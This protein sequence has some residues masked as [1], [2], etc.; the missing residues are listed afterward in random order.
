MSKIFISVLILAAIS[1]TLCKEPWQCDISGK[2]ACSQSQTC[3][4]SKVSQTGWSCFPTQSGVCCSDGV[5]VCPTATICNLREKRC[6]RSTLAFLEVAKPDAAIEVAQEA[7]LN[8]VPAELV[9]GFLKG[10]GFFSNLPHENECKPED[11]QIAQDISEIINLLKNISIKTDFRKTIEQILT[12]ATDAY[13]R[14][15]KVSEVCA[16]FALELQH[17]VEG[18]KGYVSAKG[19]YSKLALHTAMNIGQIT[20]KVKTAVSDYSAAKFEEAGLAF[21]D[22]T[23]FLIFWGFNPDVKV[24]LEEIEQYE[25]INPEDFLTFAA[26]VNQG[27]RFFYMLPNYDQCVSY[28]P[29]VTQIAEE[30]F[31]IVK[32]LNIKNAMDVVRKV[33]VKGLEIIDIISKQSDACNIYSKAIKNVAD[34][35]IKKI[36]EKSYPTKLVFHS[37]T[38]MKPITDK[39]MNSVKAFKNKEFENAGIT[40]GELM[41]FIF[42]WDM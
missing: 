20:E 32:G 3:C 27:F 31:N 4:R 19:Y 18:L 5:S 21:G 24:L 8:S 22:L 1:A 12:K 36:N 40:G 39:L 17:V 38:N 34:R 41:K 13:N 35:L 28:D 11:P 10:F 25:Q 16:E 33:T 7:N 30:I 15:S 26:G 23:K 29:K 6:D 42:F 37:Q 2:Y 14:I 9:D